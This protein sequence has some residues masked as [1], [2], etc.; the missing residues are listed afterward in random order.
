M[1]AYRAVGLVVLVGAVTFVVGIRVGERRSAPAVR[2]SSGDA[3]CALPV[4]P[5]A[6]KAPALKIPT[7][8]GLPCLVAFGAGGCEP[9]R[10]MVAVLSE[11]SPRLQGK[12]DLV[13]VDTE[14]Y[15]GE[16]QRWRLRMV[17]TQLLVGA[18]G[19]ELWR[20]EGYLGAQELL[21]RVTALAAAPRGKGHE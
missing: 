2:P 1:G 13:P 12:A 5:A 14:V 15:P 8:S 9:C 3:C 6:R 11:L 7:G 17:P 21:G 16:A 4:N 20:H 10:R 19:Q 18:N